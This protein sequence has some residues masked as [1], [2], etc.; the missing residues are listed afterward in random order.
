MTIRF[1][2]AVPTGTIARCLW[3]PLAVPMGT[4]S[5]R[6]LREPLYLDTSSLPQGRKSMGISPPLGGALDHSDA[7]VSASVIRGLGSFKRGDARADEF[8]RN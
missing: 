5:P 6:C 8:A 4:I 3:E 2:S 7:T 1:F